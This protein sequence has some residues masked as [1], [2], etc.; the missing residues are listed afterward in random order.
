ML[1]SARGRK[2]QKEAPHLMRPRKGRGSLSVTLPANI[3]W[4]RSAPF[5][6]ATRKEIRPTAKRYPKGSPFSDATRK[7]KSTTFR[8]VRSSPWEINKIGKV[9][10]TC[11]RWRRLQCRDS[12]DPLDRI[13]ATRTA[14]LP[15]D[16]S[17]TGRPPENG[18]ECRTLLLGRD[19]RRFAIGPGHPQT[20]RPP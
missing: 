15:L 12:S 10:E 8:E 17:R 6:D 19:G 1:G 4:K 20:A 13:P 3:D 16:T 11:G 18:G 7:V 5:S 2:L 9:F 14:A